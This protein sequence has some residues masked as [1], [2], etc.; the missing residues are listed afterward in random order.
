MGGTKHMVSNTVEKGAPKTAQNELL[1][2]M[3]DDYVIDTSGRGI[4]S[5]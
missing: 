5:I 4:P 3:L 1:E 2:Y